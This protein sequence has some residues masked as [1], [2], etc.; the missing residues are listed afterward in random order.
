MA[1]AT[2]VCTCKTCGREFEKVVYGGNRRDADSKAEWAA[3][4]FDECEDCYA[5][6]K[7]RERD[8]ANVAAEKAAK[9]AGLP[10]LIGSEKQVKWAATIRQGCY[11]KVIAAQTRNED[12]LEKRLVSGKDAS[13]AKKR[14]KQ[15]AAFAQFL[16]S[17]TSAAWWIDNRGK[18]RGVTFMDIYLNFEGEFRAWLEV[19]GDAPVTPAAPETPEEVEIRR[20]AEA[21]MVAAPQDQ[22]HAGTV[23]ITVTETAVSARYEKNDDFRAVVKRLGY[24]WD[25]DRR[26]WCKPINVTTGTAQ[27]RAAELGSNLLNA[28]FAVQIADPDTRA[29]AIEGRYQP[30]HKRWIAVYV[31]GDYKGWL[32]IFLPYGEDMYG[33]AKKLPKARYCKPHIA[34]PVSE[35]AAVEDFAEMYD[36]RFCPPALAAI[37]REKAKIIVVAPAPAKAAQYNEKNPADVLNSG[38]E[39]LDDL[40]EED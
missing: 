8:E 27:E 10:E 29:A 40:R 22:A 35:Y 7:A 20:A 25:A 36:Y 37:E 5:A 9:E 6:R 39:V 18:S 26:L 1:K 16:L 19:H 24:R 21:E 15:G 12:A 17:H 28:G 4:H 31:S 23:E 2:A 11:D 33:A 14:V 3:T 13:R 32:C 38:A 30:E 34:V